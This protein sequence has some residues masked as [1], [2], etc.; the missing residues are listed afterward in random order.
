[1]SRIRINYADLEQQSSVMKKNIQTY[2]SL[3][4]RSNSIISE[5]GSSWSGEASKS[6]VNLNTNYITNANKMVGLLQQFIKISMDVAIKFIKVDS[7]C[8]KTI[9]NS[10]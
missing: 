3:I 2:E 10:F 8:A 6:F 9:K 1:M 5:V 7:S 4:R